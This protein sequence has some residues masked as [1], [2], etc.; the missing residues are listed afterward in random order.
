MMQT[1]GQVTGVAGGIG[2][3]MIVAGLIGTKKA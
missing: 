2:A 3:A 1:V